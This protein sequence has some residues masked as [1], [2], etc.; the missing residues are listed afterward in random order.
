MRV[1]WTDGQ[2]VTDRYAKRF[3]CPGVCNIDG[4]IKE[5]V[6][7]EW[8][9]L[10]PPATALLRHLAAKRPSKIVIINCSEL[11]ASCF[12]NCPDVHL[13]DMAVQVPLQFTH[14]VTLERTSGRNVHAP[15]IQM[16]TPGPHGGWIA[17]TPMGL[18][19]PIPWWPMTLLFLL[20]DWLLATRI[21]GPAWLLICLTRR[22]FLWRTW[23]SSIDR[24]A[25]ITTP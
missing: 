25:V 3:G 4:P 21:L 14:K 15:L 2:V 1:T 11:V 22:P 12:A 18:S 19:V 7:R 9:S 5:V 10:T 8:N 13:R 20:L 6:L 17:S 23:A 24:S 16:D